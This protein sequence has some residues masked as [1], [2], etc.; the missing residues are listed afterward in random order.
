M[1]A[2]FVHLEAIPA[3]WR[4][5]RV[6]AANASALAHTLANERERARLFRTL[7]TLRADIALFDDVDELRWHGAKAGFDAAMA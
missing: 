6:N 5:W 4:E 2:K 1:L 7:A 3:D